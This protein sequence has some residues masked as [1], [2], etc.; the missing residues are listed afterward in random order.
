MA[1]LRINRD[2]ETRLGR[3]HG[4]AQ[5]GYASLAPLIEAAKVDVVTCAIAV[6]SYELHN[7]RAGIA[8]T[9]I[10]MDLVAS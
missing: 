4:V 2:Q 10:I 5:R 1:V 7:V 9:V 6:G 3:S 8:A